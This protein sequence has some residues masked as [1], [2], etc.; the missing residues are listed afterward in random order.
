MTIPG[1]AM[2]DRDLRPDDRPPIPPATLPVPQPAPSGGGFN[3][4]LKSHFY[5]FMN[6]LPDLMSGPEFDKVVQTA[7]GCATIGGSLATIALYFVPSLYDLAGPSFAPLVA[8]AAG[9]LATHFGVR[10]KLAD[11]T[12]SLGNPA[13][14][15]ITRHDGPGPGPMA[16]P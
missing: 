11:S 1:A 7:M 10:A 6:S 14:A 2:D 4:W 15:S 16:R 8:V 9:W 5:P 12:D 13:P 3:G